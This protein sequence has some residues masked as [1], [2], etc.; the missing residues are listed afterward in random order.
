MLNEEQYKL[1]LPYR[2]ALLLFEKQGEWLGGEGAYNVH[3]Q[4]TGQQTNMSCNS[5]KGRTIVELLMVLK[6]YEERNM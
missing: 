6:Q 1:I 5:C 4:I 3:R 2:D